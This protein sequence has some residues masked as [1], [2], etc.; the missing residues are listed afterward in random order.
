[1][2]YFLLA[3]LMPDYQHFCSWIKKK[4]NKNKT[5]PSGKK[6]QQIP[7]VCFVLQCL[8]T[9]S[10]TQVRWGQFRM[11]FFPKKTNVADVLCMDKSRDHILI[12]LLFFF[13]RNLYG[14][15]SMYTCQIATLATYIIPCFHI[16]HIV[17]P[18]FYMLN[19]YLYA[20]EKLQV[21]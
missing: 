11:Y 14:R 15:D 3:M 5:T 6:P 17:F 9:T 8:R 7:F 18:F 4:Q 21:V 10:F 13:T 16:Q 12:S 1:M 19:I 2:L 20:S